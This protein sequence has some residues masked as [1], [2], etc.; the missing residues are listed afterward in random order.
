MSLPG[1]PN[2]PP[3]VTNKMIDGDVG[4]RCEQCEEGKIVES[5]CCGQKIFETDTGYFCSQCQA[6]VL[7][8][9]CEACDGAGVIY[10]P[11]RAEIEERKADDQGD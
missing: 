6:Q 8:M 5:P 11:T 7:F 1:D 9:N 4:E 3:G 2:L 10:P